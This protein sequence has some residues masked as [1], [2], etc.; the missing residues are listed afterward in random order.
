MLV[1]PAGTGKTVLLSAWIDRLPARQRDQV[2]F[3]SASEHAELGD[4]LR[5]RARADDPRVLVVDDAHL[6]SA[7]QLKALAR[8]LE[9]SPDAVRMVVASR[10]DLPLPVVELELRGSAT[11][12]RGGHL[13]FD[14]KE[15]QALARAHAADITTSAIRALQARTGGWAAALVLGARTI[16]RDTLGGVAASIKA[17]QPVLDFLLGDAFTALPKPVR[18]LLVCTFDEPV[19]TPE[20][21]AVLSDNPDAGALL[22]EL[23]NDGLLVTAYGRASTGDV[24]Y[25]YHPLLIEL[26]RRRVVKV[27]VDAAALT[28]AHRR[29]AIHD[30]AHGRDVSALRQAMA[31]RDPDLVA[32][33]VVELGPTLLW[34]NQTDVVASAL[35]GLSSE[36]VEKYPQLLGVASQHRR[37]VGDMAGAAALARRAR[38]AAREVD[39]RRAR[40]RS[41]MDDALVA[42]ALLLR[43][44]QARYGWQDGPSAIKDAHQTLRCRHDSPAPAGH[45]IDLD[46]S[47]ER[48][49]WLLVELGVVEIWTGDLVSARLHVDEALVSARQVDNP[50]LLAATLSHRAFVELLSGVIHNAEETAAEA[51][52]YASQ[53]GFGDAVVNDRARLVL[54]WSAYHQCDITGSKD[55]LAQL[56]AERASRADVVLGISLCLLRASLLSEDGRLDDARR[57]LAY[58]PEVPGPLPAFL[59]RLI[60]ILRWHCA[61]LAADQATAQTQLDVLEAD[62]YRVEAKLFS[63]LAGAMSG[64]VEGAL[65]GI[66]SMIDEL[67]A[68]DAILA[69]AAAAARVA[70]LIRSGDTPAARA[71][72]ADVLSRVAPQRAVSA[73]T[74][75]AWAEPQFFDLL[76]EETQ[77]P[78]AHP[79]AADALAAL[80]RRRDTAG[81]V[82]PHAVV[83]LDRQAGQEA[84]RANGD[85]G[86]SRS[87][88]PQPR[89]EVS[90]HGFPVSLTARET[91]VLAQLALGS[92]YTEIG[93]ALFITENTVKT[94]LASLYR[95]LGVDKRSAALR[96][97]RE[98]GL[99]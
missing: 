81:V 40:T 7:V 53:T 29:A 72:I 38:S 43:L 32:R 90:L 33:L 69:A 94:H 8:P 56:D 28:A 78:D 87:R 99:L 24:V 76:I 74:A 65:D 51:L 2:V 89:T 82:G 12:I 98:L 6:L 31:A 58:P 97:S 39:R 20:R 49:A 18:Q 79:F 50:R 42:D 26:L 70:L 91:D 27:S 80:E 34:S 47:P 84:R 41:V 59:A 96:V 37:S 25:D 35:D 15:A 36:A 22:A 68:T 66:E 21:A 23:V 13:R 73:L 86:R 60:A 61:M 67:G 57:E 1:A 19:I 83:G 63:T 75:G 62:G 71:G 9:K 45:D 93:K 44:W 5:A 17:D 48:L 30:V 14:D 4:V 55:W 52:H 88:V 3:L 95:K 92:S 54:A 77:R 85:V 11:T 64:E 10:R 46:I 16:A